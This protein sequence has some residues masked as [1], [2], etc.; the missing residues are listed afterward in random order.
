MDAEIRIDFASH[1]RK[2]ASDLQ[3]LGP[4]RVIVHNALLPLFF[5]GFLSLCPPMQIRAS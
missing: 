3:A 1:G 2:P 5:I 4:S